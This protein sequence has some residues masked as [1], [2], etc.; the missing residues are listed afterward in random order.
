MSH[1]LRRGPVASRVTRA[2][3]SELMY[4]ADGTDS[5]PFQ[6]RVAGESGQRLHLHREHCRQIPHNRTPVI[7][8]IG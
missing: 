8:G 5:V 2:G 7:P 3:L 6:E 4:S 1:L